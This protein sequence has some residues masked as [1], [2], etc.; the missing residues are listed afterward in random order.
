MLNQI[1][2]LINDNKY[3]CVIVKNDELIYA[4]S[5]RGIKPLLTFYLNNKEEMVGAFLADKVIGKAAALIAVDGRI[6]SVYANMM[7]KSAL[8]LLKKNNIQV[9]YNILVN[10]ILNRDKTDICFIEKAVMHCEDIE[11]GISNIINTLKQF[12]K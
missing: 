8:E 7:S 1:K 11:Q 5:G 10:N 12:E 6:T 4:V 9:E 3:S 2:E